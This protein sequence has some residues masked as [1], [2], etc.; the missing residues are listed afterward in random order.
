MDWGT[1]T[2]IS[3][4]LISGCLEIVS[5]IYTNTSSIFRIDI[6]QNIL[7]KIK[8]MMSLNKILIAERFFLTIHTDF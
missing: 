6:Q 4:Y 8:E 1:G 5:Y 7:L 3:L 2:N